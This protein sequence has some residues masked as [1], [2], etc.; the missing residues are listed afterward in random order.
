[1]GKRVTK[2]TK[3]VDAATCNDVKDGGVVEDGVAEAVVDGAQVGTDDDDAGSATGNGV[4]AG[5]KEDSK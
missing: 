5:N 4:T 3:L 1:M 2:K